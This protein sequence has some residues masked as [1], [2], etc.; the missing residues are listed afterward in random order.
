MPL[1][2]VLVV[3]IDFKVPEPSIVVPSGRFEQLSEEITKLTGDVSTVAPPGAALALVPW[4]STSRTVTTAVVMS[5]F[6]SNIPLE[7]DLRPT[8]AACAQAPQAP[9]ARLRSRRC[10]V[11]GSRGPQRSGDS[12][13]ATA[14]PARCMTPFQ[15]LGW[16]RSGIA[17]PGRT[18]WSSWRTPG[19]RYDDWV[20]E[21]PAGKRVDAVRPIRDE[22]RRWLENLISELVPTNA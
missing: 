8:V 4:H 7:S 18:L 22:I 19:K 20:L 9:V 14:D 16:V 5:R 17:R 2:S 1:A 10:P 15:G 21:D 13:V 6:T 3:V 12:G 11:Y